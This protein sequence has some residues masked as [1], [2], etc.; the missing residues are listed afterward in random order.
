[1][2]AVKEKI[3]RSLMT[4]M[5]AGGLTTVL[6]LGVSWHVIGGLLR[7]AE[8]HQV[9]LTEAVLEV[10][11]AM[12]QVRRAEKD[13]LARDVKSEEFY[14]T[15]R[16][17][18]LGKHEKALSTLYRRVDHLR[19]WAD[20]MPAKTSALET[21]INAYASAFA[22]LIEARRKLGHGAFGLLG[23]LRTEQLELTEGGTRDQNASFAAA[24]DS[25]EH[26]ATQYLLTERAA[27][28]KKL[29]SEIDAALVLVRAEDDKT[30][31]AK[32]LGDLEAFRRDAD[33]ILRLQETI[34]L[35]EDKGLRGEMRSAIHNL[36]PLLDETHGRA[37]QLAGEAHDTQDMAGIILLLAGLIGAG[38]AFFFFAR[39]LTRP[40]ERLRDAAHELG[41]GNLDATVDVESN[42]E[43]GELA[44][45]FRRMATNLSTAEA[46]R[47]SIFS[48]ITE[49]TSRL[50]AASSEILAA[51][52]QQ[53]A[54]SEEQAA[55]VSQTV[56]TIDEVLHAAEEGAQRA[57]EVTDASKQSVEN[58]RDG[59]QAVEATIERMRK[60][61]ERSEELSAG[62]LEL[63]GRA[64][65][66]GVIIA[67]VNDIAEQTNLLALNAAIEASRAGEHGK[68]F[69]VVAA[70]VRALADECKK[71]TS[72]VRDLLGEV[73]RSTRLAV[74]RTRESVDGA[75]DAMA[76]AEQTGETIHTLERALSGQSQVAAQIN[77][78]ARQQAIGIKQINEA[79][80][81]IDQ[82]T[83]QNVD[84]NRQTQ[85]AMEDLSALGD[86]LRQLVGAN[87]QES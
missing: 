54:G 11:L 17:T 67:T 40:I 72:Q 78:S 34:G 70:E 45:A 18:Y 75:N 46:E 56:A 81:S 23:A 30:K 80:R 26:V 42:D 47:N 15:G 69:A 2:R 31:S 14:S 27:D 48:G 32:L 39:S 29:M 5:L 44:G 74:T 37:V 8:N 43:I 3:Q 61:K 87:G 20:S 41:S 64:E 38:L 1:M 21:A 53:S 58:S 57:T 24:I 52:T 16:S 86:R 65:S 76:S 77:A 83:R 55:A 51:T 66:I 85:R 9:E 59:T 63:D 71:A 60:V 36:A 82:V 7:D 4:K 50:A 62:I 13:T 22:H 73:Q 79:M 28:G 49:T 68:G 12:L 10:E 25:M 35:S 84:S 33:A 6:L 19:G